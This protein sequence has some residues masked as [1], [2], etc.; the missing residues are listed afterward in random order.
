LEAFAEGAG[1]IVSPD[2]NFVDDVPAV[3]FGVRPDTQQ[4]WNLAKKQHNFFYVDNGYFGGLYKGREYYRVSYNALH[5]QGASNPNFDRFAKFGIQIC[6]RETGPTVLICPPR[7]AWANTTV[8][9]DCDE[10]LD[11]TF[12]E[13]RDK[14]SKAVMVRF[15]PRSEKEAR[16][17]EA[18]NALHNKWALVTYMSNIAVEAVLQGVPIFVHEDHCAKTMGHTLDEL[19]MLDSPWL[20]EKEVRHEWAATLANNQWT[21]EE[22][23]DGT[24]WKALQE[25]SV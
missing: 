22:F 3:F 6:D 24:A 15:K 13:V 25:A 14:C 23:K 12:K 1:G 20:P 7:Q 21:L 2:N 5:Y 11:K 8:K 17:D 4:L 16:N 9:L 18:Y 19:H 10:W